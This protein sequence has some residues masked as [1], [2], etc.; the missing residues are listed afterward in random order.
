MKRVLI[1]SSHLGA[2]SSRLCYFLDQ[3]KVQWIKETIVYD[4]P[5]KVKLL[6]EI[7]HKYR[8]NGLFVNEVL[9]NYQ[10]CHKR[11][12]DFCNLIYFVREPNCL[13]TSKVETMESLLSHYIFRLRR[14]YEMV[15]DKGGI[16]LTWNDLCNGRGIDLLNKQFNITVQFNPEEPA[17]NLLPLHKSLIVRAQNAYER[18]I[19][20]INKIEYAL[21]C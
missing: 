15:K 6:E 5:R 7:D 12:C 19:Y 17:Y 8:S 20:R 16:I 21:K 14:M 3:T 4:H 11:I 18:F 1:V 2:N 13:R 10:I 9:F